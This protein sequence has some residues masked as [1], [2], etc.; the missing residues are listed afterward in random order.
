MTGDHHPVERNTV[1]GAH[2]DDGANR[3]LLD[4]LRYLAPVGALHLGG[5]RR[6]RHERL[7]RAPGA[8][9]GQTFQRFTQTEQKDDRRA[10]GPLLQ[11][12][13]PGHRHRHQEV[14]VQGALQPHTAQPA[15]NDLDRP[16]QD[17]DEKEA[18][19]QRLRPAEQRRSQPRT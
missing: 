1:P 10:L 5:I 18:N 15:G 11:P 3:H 13:R 16:G 19:P 7:D 9:Q 6:H 14:D 17:C 8:C 4:R 12:N 2:D